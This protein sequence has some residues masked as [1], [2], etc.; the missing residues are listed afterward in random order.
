MIIDVMRFL[1]GAKFLMAE[2]GDV[3]FGTSSK[4]SHAQERRCVTATVGPAR[5]RVNLMNELEGSSMDTAQSI[6]Y[7]GLS[8]RRGAWRGGG[9]IEG[10][11]PSLPGFLCVYLSAFYKRVLV[12]GA[13]RLLELRLLRW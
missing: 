13:L 4:P 11:S 5:G 8:R 7:A 1:R 9:G 12:A 6:A 10:R 2:A 3:L